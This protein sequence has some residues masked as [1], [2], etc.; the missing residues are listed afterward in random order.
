MSWQQLWVKKPLSLLMAEPEEGHQ[1]KRALGPV[2]LTSLGVGAIIGAG[3][4]VLSGQAAAEHAGPAIV[5]S[6]VIAGIGCAFAGLCYS[7][8]ASMIPIAGS[9]YT[10]SYATMGEFFAWII[11]WDLIL[12]YSLGAATVSVGW[13]GYV[14]SFLRDLG[15][16]IPAQFTAATGALLV[17][18]PSEGWKVLSESL[19]QSLSDKG[20]GVDTLPQMTA[21][22]NFPA[23]LIVAVVTALLV[24]GIKESANANNVVVIIKVG[25]LIIF[26]VAG[27]AYL[28]SHPGIW[29]E[30]WKEFIPPQA[31]DKQGQPIFGKYGWSGILTGAG[32]IF[33]AYIGFDAVS[34]AAQEAKNPQRDLPIGIL[35]SLV[36]CTIFY[37]AVASVLTGMVHYSQLSVA[38][39]VAVGINATGY[40]WLKPIIKIGAIAGLSSVILVML[41]AQPRIF[42]TMS[43]DGL[44]PKFMSHVHPRF[45]TPMVTTIIT[46]TVVA[47]AGGLAPI[48]ILGHLVSIGT[49]LAFV[50]V[51]AGVLVLRHTRPEINRPFRTPA[52]WFTCI[53]GILICLA[54][55]VALPLD[56]WLRLVIWMAIGIVIYFG[57]G[58]WHSKLRDLATKQAEGAKP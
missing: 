19:V 39:P 7:E 8:M 40:T 31:T 41:M 48:G 9:A 5:L 13:S 16:V 27:L 24:V 29:S 35:G 12:E 46:G 49:L 43:R 22:F 23:A 3:I 34:T 33:F 2:A 17:D 42:Y 18:V 32:V 15:I 55:M 38:D 1:L 56:T 4:F 51:C 26:L 50:L 45:K 37:I 30:N 54:Q 52:V 21:I 58:F 28:L 53:M 20:I 10:Y 57:Y 11:G 36:L 47:I 44:L 14:V 25:V 6:F